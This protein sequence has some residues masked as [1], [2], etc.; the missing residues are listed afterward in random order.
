[1]SGVG[2]FHFDDVDRDLDFRPADPTAA[3]SLS[4][5]DVASFNERGFISPL[6][7]LAGPEVDQLRDYVDWLVDEVLSADDQRNSYS[8]NQYH[9]V[10]ATVHDLVTHPTLVGY[11]TDLLGDEVVCWSTH[12]FCKLPGDGMEVPFHQDANYWPFDPASSVSVWIAIDDVDEGNAAM[13][14]VPGSHL[15]GGLH[16]VEVPLDGSVVLNRTIEDRSLLVDPFVN[17]LRAGQVSLHSDLLLHGS[18]ANTSQRRRAGYAVRYLSA[19][20]RSHDPDWTKAAV[21]VGAGDPGG[22]WPNTSRPAGEE[23]HRMAGF[24]GGFDGTI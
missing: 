14:F 10:C 2:I 17:E 12:L 8:I 5:S 18:T 1:M 19:S 22:Y 11:A 15:G 6:P 16:H 3:T 13:Q 24:R 7:F 9:R 20:A 4:A 21:H 23:P